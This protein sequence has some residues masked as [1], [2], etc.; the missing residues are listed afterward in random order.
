MR[1]ID[2]HCRSLMGLGRDEYNYC[3]IHVTGIAPCS[4]TIIISCIV[5]CLKLCRRCLD[6]SLVFP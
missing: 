3:I 5:V 1:N 2:L 6:I 4:Q